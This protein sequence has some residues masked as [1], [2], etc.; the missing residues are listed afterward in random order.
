MSRKQ[1][2]SLRQETREDSGF[3]EALRRLVSRYPYVASGNS[4][5]ANGNLPRSPHCF[6]SN[7]RV[8]NF[9][10]RIRIQKSS[11]LGSSGFTR[12][13]CVRD[14]RAHLWDSEPRRPCTPLAMIYP[15]L[16]QR[17]IRKQCQHGHFKRQNCNRRGCTIIINIVRRPTERPAQPR[18]AKGRVDE[19]QLRPEAHSPVPRE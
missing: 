8:S 16:Q 2:K 1:V 6:G 19:E 9:S 13:R 7:P 5:S 18:L 17:E 11:A 3:P 4:A 12:W 10:W 14:S 15:C